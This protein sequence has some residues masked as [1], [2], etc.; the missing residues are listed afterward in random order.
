MLSKSRVL[1]YKTYQFMKP[2]NQRFRQ[3]KVQKNVFTKLPIKENTILYESF[4][5]RNYSDSPKA[6]FTYL[7]ENDKDKWNH[8]WILNDKNLV[9]NEQEFKNENVKIIK[10]FGWQYFYYVTVSKYFILNMRQP[11]WL[12]KKQ[13]K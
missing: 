5:G 12:Y 2:K 11:K 9:E 3:K 1:G 8:V 6:I 4:L 10:R 13:N 7:L